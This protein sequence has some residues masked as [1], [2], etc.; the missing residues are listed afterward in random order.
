MGVG[1]SSRWIACLLL[2]ASSAAAQTGGVISGTVKDQ[3]GAVL[4]DAVV[5]V[6]N[7]ESGVAITV[8]TNAAGMYRA[9]SLSPGIYRLEVEMPGFER[10]VRLK[11][12][13]AVGQILAV[14]LALQVGSH[15]DTVNVEASASL[16]E[17]Q[18]SDVTQVINRRMVAGL[19]MPNR[20]ATSLVALAPGI[21]MVD[22][23]SGAENYPV[24][25]V[26]GGRVR[27]QNFT[28]DGGSVNNAVGLTRPQ[29]MTSLPMD[30][31]Q[32]FRVISNN[33]A[34]EYGH[35]T[36]GIINLSTRAGTNEFHGS[37]FEDARN[38]AFDAR[39]FF[40]AQRTPIRMHQFGASLGGPIRKDRTHFF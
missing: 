36:G 11:L 24:F 19:P 25:S 10:L 3:T 35:S 17:T 20:A 9:A 30:A 15:N 12:P 33:Y 34:A 40:A 1:S 18:S 21:V 5:R 6:V 28:L 27:N 22:P 37:I 38:D 4:P 14:D 39:N 16:V 29:Q 32:E 7:E 13:L 31:M 2:L 8:R 26:A 23:G